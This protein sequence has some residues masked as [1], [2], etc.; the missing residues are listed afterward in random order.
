MQTKVYILKESYVKDI[1][2]LV[3]VVREVGGLHRC[4][5]VEIEGVR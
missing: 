1:G 3:V 5:D 2:A 4:D